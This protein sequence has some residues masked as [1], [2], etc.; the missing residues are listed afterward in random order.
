VATVRATVAAFPLIR[1]VVFCCHS[2][3]DLAIY[4]A[5]LAA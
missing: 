1:E 3:E 2:A 5:L 4:Q